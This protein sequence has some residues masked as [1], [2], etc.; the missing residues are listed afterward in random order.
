MLV[1]KREEGERLVIGDGD[2]RVVIT[3]VQIVIALDKVWIGLEM[4]DGMR[5]YKQ[6]LLPMDHPG[7]PRQ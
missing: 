2:S 4:P 1:L 6:E 3:V 7:G 5:A